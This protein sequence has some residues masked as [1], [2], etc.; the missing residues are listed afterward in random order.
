MSLPETVVLFLTQSQVIHTYTLIT[1][2]TI[3]QCIVTLFGNLEMEIYFHWHKH[4]KIMVRY[5]VVICNFT[6]HELL[7]LVIIFQSI[8]S[9]YDNIFKPRKTVPAD[10]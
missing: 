7:K 6:S 8:S 9:F 2:I 3:I 1:K 4:Y 5:V 10:L